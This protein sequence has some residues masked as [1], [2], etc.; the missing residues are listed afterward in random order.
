MS[1]GFTFNDLQIY[2]QF[3]LQG[4]TNT[5]AVYILLLKHEI[6]AVYIIHNYWMIQ[7]AEYWV[8]FYVIFCVC[9]L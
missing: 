3:K 8:L 9:F 7:T 6:Y 2:I 5:D 4:D 1:I